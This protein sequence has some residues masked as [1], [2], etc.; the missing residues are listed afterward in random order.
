MYWL[1]LQ[2]LDLLMYRFFNCESLGPFDAVFL[3]DDA[4]N[5]SN[6]ISS[7]HYENFEYESMKKYLLEKSENIHKCR[8]KLTK[9]MGVWWFEK[10]SP[11]E[12]EKKKEAV[13]TRLEDV[14]DE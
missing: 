10:M 6:V 8:S 11:Q 5:R 12:W 9:I 13:I 3:C 4:K 7:F 14:H 2:I 1:Y